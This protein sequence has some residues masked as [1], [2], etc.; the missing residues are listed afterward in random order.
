ML[1]YDI[2]HLAMSLTIVSPN[3]C[4]QS[5]YTSRYVCTAV[6]LDISLPVKHHFNVESTCPVG[7]LCVRPPY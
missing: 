2:V 5:V 6:C 1:Y 4:P 3:I 7:C